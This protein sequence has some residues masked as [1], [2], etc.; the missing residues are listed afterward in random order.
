[1]CV[2][3]IFSVCI[4]CNYMTTTHLPNTL[5]A[6]RITYWVGTTFE[7]TSRSLKKYVLYSMNVI[8]TYYIRHVV[9]IMWPTSISCITSIHKSSPVASWNRKVS[10]ECTLQ[11][12]AGSSRSSGVFSPTV[13]RTLRIRTYY[14]FGV[15]FF[16]YYIV[17]KYSILD[18]ANE[19]PIWNNSIPQCNGLDLIFQCM[20]KSVTNE[21]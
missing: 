19:Y 8:W 18:A 16:A 5:P 11:N 12:L 10:I 9:T 20:T 2:V 7:F 13:F 21:P 14:S 6:S 17:G 1:M 3:C 15:L 4:E